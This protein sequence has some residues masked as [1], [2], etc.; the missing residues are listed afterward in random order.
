MSLLDHDDDTTGYGQVC[1]PAHTHGQPISKRNELDS[2]LRMVSTA[3]NDQGNLPT[4]MCVNV[5]VPMDK[6]QATAPKHVQPPKARDDAQ[7][8]TQ[9]DAQPDDTEKVRREVALRVSTAHIGPMATLT[10]PKDQA[11][12]AGMSC[13]DDS[14][15]DS[16][17]P[18]ENSRRVFPKAPDALR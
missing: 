6:A 9:D 10:R 2:S 7:P 17:S 18:D 16:E 8:L 12:I 11:P 4:D 5:Q 3:I 15:S 13:Y 1:C 14:A